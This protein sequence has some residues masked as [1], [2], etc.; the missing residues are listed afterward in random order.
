MIGFNEAIERIR[1][2][3]TPLGT[4]SLSLADAVG[5]V[6][7]APVIAAIDSPRSDV[8]TMDGYAVREADLGSLPASLKVVG[9]SLPGS[10]WAGPVQPGECARI[11]TGAPV[12]PDADRVIMQENVRRDGDLAI[13]A[14]HPGAGRHIRK[15]ASDFAAGDALLPAGRLLDPRAMVAAAAADVDRVEVAAS[16]RLHILTTGDEL[17][18]PGTARGTPGAISDSISLGVAALAREWGA[19]IVGRLRLRDDVDSMCAAA[20]AAISQADVVVVTGGASVGTKDFAK[21]MFEP[22]GLDLIFSTVAIKP[23]KPAWLGRAAKA[24][25]VG[26]PGNPTSAMVTARLLLAPLLAGLR[27]QAIEAALEWRSAPLAV[28]LGECGGRETFHR[29]R[30]NGNAVELSPNQDSGAQKAL[31]DAD[32]LVRQRPDSAALAAGA[33]VETLA[34]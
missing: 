7:A 33:M 13:I 20:N 11:F 21:A 8:S 23:G 18:E 9:E 6:L 29:G 31:A 24:L 22:S 1:S 27:G 2:V 10:G 25:V 30:W 4:E 3:A 34:F 32:L 17:T 14:G 28:P 19:K 12:P 5:R 16:V 15:R 26:L